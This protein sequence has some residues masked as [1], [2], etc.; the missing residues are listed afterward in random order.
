MD[1]QALL[2]Q[3]GTTDYVI[4][5]NAEGI[6]H[7]ESLEH[8]VAGGSCMNWVVGHVNRARAGMVTLLG[9]EAPFSSEAFSNYRGGPSN[10]FDPDQAIPFGEL[11]EQ[12]DMFQKP[13]L[14]GLRS[15]SPERLAEKAPFSPT[16]NPDETIGS[17]LA[18][19][20]FH[21]AYHV[22]QM[23]VLRRVVGKPGVITPPEEG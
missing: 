8:P 21:E 23:G 11:M 10:P 1:T 13:I 12:Y 4:K 5:K 14:E 6:T 17:L 3:I 22:G 15:I 16:G 18:T 2:T 9:K 7:A 19:F 20:A